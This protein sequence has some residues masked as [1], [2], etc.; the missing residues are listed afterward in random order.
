MVTE[1]LKKHF[2]SQ[3]IALIPK[4]EGA[5]LFA[6]EVCGANP[7]EVELVIGGLA[8]ES[9]SFISNQARAFEVE[10]NINGESC[11]FLEDHQINGNRVVPIVWV[12]EWFQR[13]ARSLCP[14]LTVHAVEDLRV[15]NGVRIPVEKDSVTLTIRGAEAYDAASQTMNVQLTALDAQGVPRYAGRV[16]LK[17]GNGGEVQPRHDLPAFGDVW[18]LDE[19]KLY[20]EYLFHGPGFQNIKQLTSCG[21]AGGEGLLAGKGKREWELAPEPI[22][23]PVLL[24]GGLQLVRLWG[25]QSRGQASLPMRI[26]N[27]WMAPNASSERE[28][29]RCVFHIVEHGP[30]KLIADIRFLDEQQACLAA[31][32]QV[33]MYY[34]EERRSV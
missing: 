27:V 23:N 24:D 19:T 11:P 29:V 31:M 10:L 4:K 17:D 26:G 12:Q 2:E 22:S 9:P 7:N 1:T 25:Y 34:V 16:V 14:E 5:L 33:E 32:E 8:E 6:E 20:E 15:L 13:L 21:D 30:N 28:T 3:G 18:K